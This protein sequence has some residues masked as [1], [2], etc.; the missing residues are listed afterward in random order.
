MIGTAI[1]FTFIN[2]F[3]HQSNLMVMGPGKKYSIRSFVRFRDPVDDRPSV[4]ALC[5]VG[6]LLWRD[7]RRRLE[8][9][10][11]RGICHD[12]HHHPQ[13]RNRQT[14]A[15]GLS[16]LAGGSAL[17]DGSTVK[18]PRTR[19]RDRQ[20]RGPADGSTAYSGPLKCIRVDLSATNKNRANLRSNGQKSGCGSYA[21]DG[22]AILYGPQAE[23]VVPVGRGLLDQPGPVQGDEQAARRRGVGRPGRLR[24]WDG[25]RKHRLTLTFGRLHTASRPIGARLRVVSGRWTPCLCRNGYRPATEPIRSLPPRGGEFPT[26]SSPVG[27]RRAHPMG[28]GLDSKGLGRSRPIWPSA[29]RPAPP[30]RPDGSAPCRSGGDAQTW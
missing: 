12:H 15:L 24:S 25:L 9:H 10:P 7:H 14:F 17:A 28:V 5:A 26:T 23:E 21:F 4:L 6:Y 19:G 22:S 27:S 3:G 16:A 20:R 30:Q 18:P 1:S 13:H 29:P 8:M 11:S 2:P